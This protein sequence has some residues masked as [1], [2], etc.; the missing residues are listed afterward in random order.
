MTIGS[1]FSLTLLPMLDMF[2][3]QCPLLMPKMPEVYL[4]HTECLRVT[5]DTTERGLG[6]LIV[7]YETR[8]KAVQNS[9]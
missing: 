5:T 2:W 8:T 7:V 4:L 6:R 1:P 3:P 9:T